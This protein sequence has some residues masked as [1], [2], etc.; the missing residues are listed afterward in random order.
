MKGEHVKKLQHY[1][2][3][4]LK[5]MK[6]M[7]FKKIDGQWVKIDEEGEERDVPEPVSQH[8]KPVAS[9]SIVRLAENQ[10]EEIVQHFLTVFL[11]MSLGVSLH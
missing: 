3:Y 5:S 6:R 11:I 7:E 1:D 9:S 4:N 8:P 10:I 2:T